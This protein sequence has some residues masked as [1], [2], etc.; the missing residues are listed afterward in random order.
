MIKSWRY[1]EEKTRDFVRKGTIGGN[2]VYI[3]T[4]EGWP[5]L[6]DAIVQM[7]NDNIHDVFMAP[8]LLCAGEHVKNDMLGESEESWLNRLLK[9]GFHVRYSSQG[10]SAYEQIMQYYVTIAD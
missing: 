10:L 4:V 2:H 9:H 1:A 8:F 5:T 3:A 7:K 6:E